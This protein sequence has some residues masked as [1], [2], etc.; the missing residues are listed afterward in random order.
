MLSGTL[1]DG[2]I[3]VEA[4][5]DDV[6]RIVLNNADITNLSGSAIYAISADKVI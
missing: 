1:D 2:T 4:G 6:V 3:V 5:E